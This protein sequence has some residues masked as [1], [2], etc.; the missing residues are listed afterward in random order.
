MYLIP[1]TAMFSVAYAS[2]LN[3]VIKGRTFIHDLAPDDMIRVLHTLVVR[4]RT[5]L[6]MELVDRSKA[7]PKHKETDT[8]IAAAATGLPQV[9]HELIA[10]FVVGPRIDKL[11]LDEMIA[12]ETLLFR[13]VLKQKRPN[14]IFLPL[15]FLSSI[16]WQ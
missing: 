5:D 1:T 4:G 6:A 3:D 10:D 16:C 12:D 13:A 7:S 15:P 11:D 8:V 14:A 2:V 9:L